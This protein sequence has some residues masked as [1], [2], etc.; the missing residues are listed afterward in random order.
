MSGFD[1]DAPPGGPWRSFKPHP[2]QR[3]FLEA[4]ERG[5]RFRV[6]RD[7]HHFWPEG[8]IRPILGLLR[9]IQRDRAMGFRDRALEACEG[10][11]V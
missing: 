10:M 1:Y 5:E 4:A 8:E 11:G 2:A 3:R 6:V 9:G 7:E